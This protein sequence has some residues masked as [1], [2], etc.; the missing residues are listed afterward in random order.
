M[1][2]DKDLFSPIILP[3]ANGS[4]SSDDESQDEK[5]KSA[6]QFLSLSNAQELKVEE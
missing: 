2:T 5:E 4:D 3:S 1:I 6:R